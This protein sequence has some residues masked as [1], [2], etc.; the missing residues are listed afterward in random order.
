MD[1][2][3][4]PFQTYSKNGAT[5]MS[6]E[7]RKNHLEDVDQHRATTTTLLLVALHDCG[8]R[9]SSTLRDDRVHRSNTLP[10]LNS[11]TTYKTPNNLYT[12][13][14]RR[15]HVSSCKHPATRIYVHNLTQTSNCMTITVNRYTSSH[16]CLDL[17]FSETEVTP[18]RSLGFYLI[19]ATNT[20]PRKGSHVHRIPTH[21]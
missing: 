3:I 18:Y 11:P 15:K 13:T 2:Y 7:S 9:A 6:A 16:I 1:T 21:Y 20:R 17:P 8:P 12:V 5:L 10:L 4:Y 19:I 14:K